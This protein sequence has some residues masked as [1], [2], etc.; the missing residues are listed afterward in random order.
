MPSAARFTAIEPVTPEPAR[1]VRRAVLTQS[2]LDLAFLHW[3]LDP[4]AVQPLLPRGTRPDVI[5]GRTYVGLIAFRM[6]RTGLFELPGL[7]WLGSFPETNV[8]V[9]SVDA[10]GR[11]G[12]VFLSM[13]AAR[14]LPVLVGRAALGLPYVWSRM[15]PCG[16]PAMWC[17]TAAVG[18]CRRARRRPRISGFES[19]RRLANRRRWSSS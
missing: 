3:A 19:V 9:Y 17:A 1:P 6:H 18:T 2:W 8:R 7:P 13:D 15:C 10:A 4:E 16:G 11:R 12:V 14:L 5:D